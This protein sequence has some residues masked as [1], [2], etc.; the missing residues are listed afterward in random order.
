MV[1]K[2]LFYYNMPFSANLKYKKTNQKSYL[3]ATYY[4]F[5]PMST[6]CRCNDAFTPCRNYDIAIHDVLKA[7]HILGLGIMLSMA[8]L[9]MAK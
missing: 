3:N 6:Y 7:V 9:S 1:S 2:Q 5:L 4:A 8:I